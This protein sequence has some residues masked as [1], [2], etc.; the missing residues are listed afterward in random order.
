M[1]IKKKLNPLAG[2]SAMHGLS[3]LFVLIMIVIAIVVVY[4]STSISPYRERGYMSMLKLDLNNAHKAAKAYL[5]AHPKAIIVSEDQL[6]SK[7]WSKSDR[8]VFI[9]ADMTLRKGQIV[10]KNDYF[11]KQPQYKPGI[12]R[13]S[14]DGKI[15]LPIKTPAT[16]AGN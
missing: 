11:A 8:N 16:N 3:V 15:V 7:G 9:S 1:M 10:L 14:F 2:Q 13:I 6:K 12:G 5:A 4:A